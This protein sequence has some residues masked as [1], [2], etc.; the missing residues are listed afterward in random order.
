MSVGNHAIESLLD[1]DREIHRKGVLPI[2]LALFRASVGSR[3][4][5]AAENLAL[6]QQLAVLKRSVKR[7]KLRTRDR[8]FWILLSRLWK[9]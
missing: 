3:A 4:A 9:G 2:L 5:L 1:S 6:R 8:L 7:P